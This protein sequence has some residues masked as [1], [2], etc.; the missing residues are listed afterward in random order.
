MKKISKFILASSLLT[1]SMEA[2]EFGSMGNIS[3]SMGGAGVALRNSQWALYYN[4]ALLG[5]DRKSRFAYSFGV[6]IR[7]TNLLS[8]AN[9]KID[10][11]DNTSIIGG[12][13]LAGAAVLSGA[14]KSSGSLGFNQDVFQ[15]L[16]NGGNVQTL[17]A[18]AVG[19]SAASS[20]SSAADINDAISKF[21]AATLT[22]GK[23]NSDGYKAF[24]YLQTQML[25]AIDK[26]G[27]D[28]GVLRNIVQNLT[29]S[30]V[31]GVA[32]LIQK[33]DSSDVSIGDVLQ[34]LGSVKFTATPDNK[35]FIDTINIL[36]N[37][38][39][40]NDM[41][42]ASQNGLVAQIGGNGPD[43]RGAIAFGLFGSAFFSASASFDPTHNQ[44]ILSTD[45]GSY[46]K[47][48][49]NS[50]NVTLSNSS[51]VDYDN[52]S[53]LSDNAQHQI[54]A[55]GLL[56]GE[57][58]IGYGQ[59][60]STPVGN[61]SIG[62]AA[63]YIF[64]LGQRVNEV[65]SF[66]SISN[67]PDG[68]N[69]SSVVPQNTFG[70]DFG[71][72]Y[73]YGGFNLGIVGKDLNS[74]SISINDGKKIV[75]DPQFR[76]GI[77]YEWRFLSLAMDMDLKPNNTLSY[78]SPKNQMIGGGVMFDFKYVDLRLGSMYDMRSQAGEG[79]IFTG[80]INILGFLDLAVQSNTKLENV[81]GTKIPSYLSV[82]IGG[83]FSW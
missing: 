68:L 34:T 1:G 55:T 24:D 3:S 76:A 13:S 14:S 38:L 72:L 65:G 5:M 60:F 6:N 79:I 48:D 41:S 82:K 53:L 64:A 16:L 33:G 32:D 61:F 12:S 80:G 78:L 18:N 44:I 31:N 10:S 26:T 39:D 49:V 15:Q 2:L 20:I 56:L 8:L 45:D 83:G 9:A 42:I 35:D 62:F 77:S 63:K 47:V 4:P 69:L 81:A 58:P 28:T 21:K 43:G 54:N 73:N 50:D 30:Q 46:V 67:G 75:L 74:P 27:D 70:I 36:K 11:L 25:S 29:P 40:K 59:A 66:N 19:G 71:A 57:I 7:E 52:H 22:D 23:L 51:K 37:V 17:L